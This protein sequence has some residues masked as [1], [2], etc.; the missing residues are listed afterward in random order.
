MKS[1]QRSHRAPVRYSLRP[2]ETQEIVSH[3]LANS[4][5]TESNLNKFAVRFG[6]SKKT[7]HQA[8][9]RHGC[10]ILPQQSAPKAIKAPRPKT[11]EKTGENPAL[12]SQN[13][14]PKE[15][16]DEIDPL[17]ILIT[18]EER[19]R[20]DY[21]NRENDILKVAGDF[22]KDLSAREADLGT[23]RERVRAAIQQTR[24]LRI[25]TRA[26]RDLIEELKGEITTLKIKTARA[27]LQRQKAKD[28]NIAIKKE[29]RSSMAR[30]RKLLEVLERS[31]HDLAALKDKTGPHSS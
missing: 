7:I 11:N 29:L 27:E 26:D 15:L 28:A 9:T 18:E 8:V 6:C 12:L 5:M 4:G 2:E 31:E 25:A 10:E 16:P 17:E 14:P 21:E 19:L 20:A 30:E 23:Q 1:Q 13:P 22:E 24:E 3:L